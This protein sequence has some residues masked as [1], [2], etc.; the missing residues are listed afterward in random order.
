MKC[1]CDR[2]RINDRKHL[3]IKASGDEMQQC[4][5]NIIS[6]I[7]L[8]EAYFLTNTWGKYEKQAKI[9]VSQRVNF[10]INNWFQAQEK[11]FK[12]WF[13]NLLFV[14]YGLCELISWF[15]STVVDTARWCLQ[16]MITLCC[17][18]RLFTCVWL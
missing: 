6:L 10:I 12:R 7:T 4:N 13:W 11:W 15:S 1:S 14:T 3:Q 8:D 9:S 17:S 5:E 18:S 16:S 2:A